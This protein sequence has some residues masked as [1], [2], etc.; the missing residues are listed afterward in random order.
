MNFFSYNK[1]EWPIIKRI[2]RKRRFE[3]VKQTVFISFFSPF[4]IFF[5]RTSY[6]MLFWKRNFF[7]FICVCCAVILI[8]N[9]FF[10]FCFVR[11]LLLEAG[12]KKEGTRFQN[13]I[14]FA[15]FLL[16]DEK[17]FMQILTLVLQNGND[18]YFIFFREEWNLQFRS[19][20]FC[21]K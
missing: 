21:I 18:L 6:I 2:W 14:K 9:I 20:W 11:A 7:L 1:V 5:N 8:H 17:E 16:M 4:S 3:S 15:S 12:R 13:A 19:A 10:C